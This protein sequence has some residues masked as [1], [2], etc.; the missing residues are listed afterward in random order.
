MKG[1]LGYLTV[2]DASPGML[3][4]DDPCSSSRLSSFSI[5]FSLEKTSIVRCGM[6][7][8][9]IQNMMKTVKDM[10]IV[11]IPLNNNCCRGTRC[12]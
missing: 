11:D 9:M 7:D 4:V 12:L 8:L 10:K 6:N 2:V 1:M 3:T 5:G